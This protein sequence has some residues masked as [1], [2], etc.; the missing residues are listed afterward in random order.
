MGGGSRS[1]AFNS[2]NIFNS[3]SST[4]ITSSFTQSVTN[5]TNT[6]IVQTLMSQTNN[7]TS[8]VAAVNAINISN[9]GNCGPESSVNIT[10]LQQLNEIQVSPDI[11]STGDYKGDLALLVQ[12][13]ISNNLSAQ[14]TLSNQSAVTSQLENMAAG[15]GQAFGAA[16]NATAGCVGAV[17]NA[18]NPLANNVNQY[19]NHIRSTTIQNSVNAF[20][21]TQL[22]WFNQQNTIIKQTTMEMLNQVIASLS[23]VNALNIGNACKVVLTDIKQKNSIE[24]NLKLLASMTVSD[25]FASTMNTAVTNA[26]KQLGL[27][28]N[29]TA[30]GELAA[31]TISAQAIMAM[32]F[33]NP[34]NA[35]VFSVG[36]VVSIVAIVLTIC[37]ILISKMGGGGDGDDY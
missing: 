31:L 27:L 5:I 20:F 26:T 25:N 19:D 4:N 32:L 33:A 18:L 10:G 1:S 6:T 11:K 12:S 16:V 29:S 23:G 3:V 2:T 35:T 34:V 24:N 9:N 21:T 15:A 30:Q 36:I 7:I 17:C 14:A 37:F 28:T 22:T 8:Y 13:N